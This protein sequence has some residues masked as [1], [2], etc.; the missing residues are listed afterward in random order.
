MNFEPNEENNLFILTPIN[1][2]V[3]KAALTLLEINTNT[4]NKRSEEG[5]ISKEIIKSASTFSRLLRK[6]NKGFEE[7]S[8][9]N[10]VQNPSY[11][12]VGDD[13]NTPTN[14]TDQGFQRESCVLTLFLIDACL[15]RIDQR[16]GIASFRD[17]NETNYEF[18]FSGEKSL[19]I[20]RYVCK[21]LPDDERAYQA[22]GAPQETH[23]SDRIGTSMPM[24]NI[25]RDFMD[26]DFE[27]QV[28]N[29]ISTN[30]NLYIFYF[31]I[32]NNKLVF[33]IRN[34]NLKKDFTGEERISESTL[35]D[36]I[37]PP[38]S[39]NTFKFILQNYNPEKDLYFFEESKPAVDELLELEYYKTGSIF[40]DYSEDCPFE[41]PNKL[42]VKPLKINNNKTDSFSRNESEKKQ[43]QTSEVVT[44]SEDEILEFVS[45]LTDDQITFL[46]GLIKGIKIR[47]KANN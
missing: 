9:N 12:L 5:L 3:F 46:D 6:L 32:T 34:K 45:K 43:F 10:T 27:Y 38:D 19:A 33:Y 47:R 22:W 1:L 40:Y 18:I 2:S 11:F 29:L 17:K 16:Y 35:L 30:I 21:E 42:A 4:F 31:E 23:S 8:L 14:Y 44:N 25:I 26:D 24:F 41:G 39:W 37:A 7:Y 28:T 36:E 13:R 20:K 15:R